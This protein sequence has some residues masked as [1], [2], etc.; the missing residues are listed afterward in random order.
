MN[1]RI[2]RLNREILS[3][4]GEIAHWRALPRFLINFLK[5]FHNSQIK[6]KLYSFASNN[7]LIRTKNCN[8]NCH[9]LKE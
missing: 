6:K 5:Q 4:K 8:Y 3:T 9:D 2:S 7:L 1:T